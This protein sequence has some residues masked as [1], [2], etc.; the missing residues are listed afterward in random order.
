MS[1]IK[2]SYKI[3]K[4][5]NL[6][7]EYHSGRLDVDSLI[8]FKKRIALDPLFTPNL[9]YFIH[10]KNVTFTSIDEAE[11]DISIFSKFINTNFKVYGNNMRVAI[12]TNTPSQVVQA[13]RFKMMQ[14]NANHCVDI[15]SRYE[16]AMKWL[17][18]IDLEIEKLIEVLLDLKKLKEYHASKKTPF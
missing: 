10:S 1:E 3:L 7:V 18:I 12:I 16:N 8:D 17:G 13:T 14:E 5:H 15:F 2:S 4:E 11:N 9:N 6:I